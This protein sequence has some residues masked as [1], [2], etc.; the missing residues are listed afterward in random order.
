MKQLFK[1][2]PQSCLILILGILLAIPQ[3]G[4]QELE[5]Y[6][7]Y[8]GKVIDQASNDGLECDNLLWCGF[9]SL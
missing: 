9:L 7:E 2:K 3:M 4:A 6:T 1:N 5:N 8:K